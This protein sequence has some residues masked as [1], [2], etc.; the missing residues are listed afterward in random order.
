MKPGAY[1]PFPYSA[2]INRPK[3]S[4][5][6][7]ARVALWLIPNIEFFSLAEQVPVGSGG[8]GTPVP[9]VPTWAVR[10][11]GNRIGVFRLMK[12]MDRFGMR[13]TV[14]LNSEVCSQHPLIIDEALKRGWEFMGHNESN[15]RRLNELPPAKQAESIRSTLTTIERATG[16]RPKGW[17][18]SGLQE[19]WDTADTLAAEGCSYVADWPND[20][21]PYLMNLEQ[22][23]QLVSV[24]YS[25]E[26][27]DK[28]AFEKHHY[29]PREFR[30]MICRQFDVLYEEGAEN[31]RVMAIAV[32]PYLIGMPHRIRRA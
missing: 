11:Y 19:F 9:D 5:P 13:G 15:T 24:P 28:P 20:D 7:N 3:T 16:T 2:I 21:Q 8:T 12:T 26:L 1:G 32:H 23:K 29:T 31:G 6:Q 25:L 18:G 10:D 17:L 30:D 4:W 22:G 27:N 14:A